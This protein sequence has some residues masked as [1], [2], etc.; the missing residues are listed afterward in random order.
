MGQPVD[1]MPGRSC[2]CACFCPFSILSYQLS[3]LDAMMSG[4]AGNICTDP[5]TNLLDCSDCGSQARLLCTIQGIVTDRP[6]L[7]FSNSWSLC[8]SG[9]WWRA[10]WLLLLQGCQTIKHTPDV[11]RLLLLSACSSACC[12]YDSRP[13]L[14]RHGMAV[15][16]QPMAWDQISMAMGLTQQQVT[17]L[18]QLR[19][20]Y[21]AAVRQLLSKRHAILRK[22]Q[23]NSLDSHMLWR[24]SR[25]SSLAQSHAL[26]LSALA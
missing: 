26:L 8:C 17:A 13:R 14:E 7:A 22:I 23:V 4:H 18:L 1:E 6:G 5:L 2:S 11:K 12:T 19:R 15:Q 24:Y 20:T 16:M 25:T 21:L 10:Y 3:E 9:V